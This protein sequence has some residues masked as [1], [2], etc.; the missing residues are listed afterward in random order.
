MK[1]GYSYNM[2]IMKCFLAQGLVS[3]GVLSTYIK[4]FK[5]K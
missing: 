2:L 3:T 4:F 5:I 1:S